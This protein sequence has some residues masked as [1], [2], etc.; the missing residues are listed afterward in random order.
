MPRRVDIKLL[1]ITAAQIGW[2]DDLVEMLL[3][4]ITYLETLYLHLFELKEY[5]YNKSKTQK[6][7]KL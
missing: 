6:S 2:P 4:D 3:G 5:T 7:S 1:K